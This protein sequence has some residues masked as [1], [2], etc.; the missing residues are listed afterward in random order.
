M[1]A[2]VTHPNTAAWARST[3]TWPSDMWPVWAQVSA[4][5]YIHGSS[6][7]SCTPTQPAGSYDLLGQRRDHECL[8]LFIQ[9]N[10]MAQYLTFSHRS[11]IAKLCHTT[12]GSSEQCGECR[13]QPDW[14]FNEPLDSLNPQPPLHGL[15]LT[16]FLD[17]NTRH[18]ECSTR[19]VPRLGTQP[20][21]N[22]NNCNNDS[23][24]CRGTEW[25]LQRRYKPNE[26]DEPGEVSYLSEFTDT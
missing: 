24:T 13:T 12:P 7:I 18:V 10:W 25:K 14:L 1:H 21:K 3:R 17:C 11:L 2:G 4:P 9:S 5:L 8:N 23:Y 26:R 15:A 22:H 19:C 6:V 20:N 16:S